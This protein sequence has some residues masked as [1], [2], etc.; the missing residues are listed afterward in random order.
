M[1]LAILGSTEFVGKTLVKKALAAGHSVTALARD[2][3]KLGE[4]KDQVE[5]VVGE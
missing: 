1:K 4:L 5:V 2:P 3:A